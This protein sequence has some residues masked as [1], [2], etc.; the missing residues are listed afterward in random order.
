MFVFKR[1]RHDFPAAY[2]RMQLSDTIEQSRRQG[3][4]TTVGILLFAGWLPHFRL[5]VWG[6]LGLCRA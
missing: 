3:I 6:C 1:C 2:R 4:P 5:F